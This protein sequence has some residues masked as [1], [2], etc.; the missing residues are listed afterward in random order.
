M[1]TPK[2]AGKSICPFIYLSFFLS[3]THT[4]RKFTIAIL[5]IDLY[6]VCIDQMSD[7]IIVLDLYFFFKFDPLTFLYT[8]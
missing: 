3:H 1:S 5:A 7:I 4:Y 6:L 8:V 2:N